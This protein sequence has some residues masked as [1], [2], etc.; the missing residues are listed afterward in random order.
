VRRECVAFFRHAL[1][2]PE[3]VWVVKRPGGS[4]GDDTV[5]NPDM[6]ALRKEWLVDPNAKE[7]ALEC[8]LLTDSNPN[9]I[10]QRY[11]RNPLLLKGKKMEIRTYWIIASL[12]PPIALY[13]DGTVRLTTSNYT[14]GQ[15]ND[16]LIH[17]TNTKQQKL[18]DPN[19]HKT[20]SDRKWNLEQLADYLVEAGSIKN[21]KTWLDDTLRPQ[22]KNIISIVASGAWPY[23]V[24]Q[25]EKAGWDGR[26]EILG[27]DVILDTNLKLWLTEIQ[28]GPGI[29][30]DPGVKAKMLPLMLEELANIGMEVDR[31]LR[32]GIQPSNPPLSASNWTSINIQYNQKIKQV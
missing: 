12:E 25:K 5:V 17:I 15:W 2:E 10:L 8:K 29:S 6:N 13:H 11:I 7:S 30:L 16:P 19:Y 4:Q 14:D 28:L 18:A 24:A 27:M 23:L 32:K 1:R 22:L 9:K 31:D 3:T 21:A 20:E 26:F